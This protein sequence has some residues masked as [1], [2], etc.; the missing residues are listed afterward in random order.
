MGLASSFFGRKGVLTIDEIKMLERCNNDL[1]LVVPE[2]DKS[3]RQYFASLRQL[4]SEILDITK[5]K[6]TSNNE[7]KKRDKW[8]LVYE[9]IKVIVNE[10]DPLGVADFVDD[11]YDDLNFKIYSTLLISKDEK[12]LFHVIKN[13]LL[14]YYGVTIP[15]DT[16]SKATT[17]LTKLDT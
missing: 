10:L 7:A 2:L 8:K 12:K 15:D 11:E 9:K 13:E 6:K 4:S 14:E 3:A 5:G 16:I 17:E 1:K